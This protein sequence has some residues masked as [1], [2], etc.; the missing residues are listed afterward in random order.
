M[1]A[2]FCW[3]IWNYR[4]K[5]LFQNKK[6]FFR[7]IWNATLTAWGIR[8]YLKDVHDPNLLQLKPMYLNFVL[9]V[10]AVTQNNSST[11]GRYLIL[12][13]N[14]V[15]CWHATGAIGSDQEGVMWQCIKYAFAIIMCLY[16]DNM[17]IAVD[18]H[19]WFQFLKNEWQRLGSDSRWAEVFTN[20]CPSLVREFVFLPRISNV[21]GEEI[22]KLGTA[23]N[24]LYVWCPGHDDKLCKIQVPLYY[25]SDQ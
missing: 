22:I 19:A 18:N 2:I 5:I 16:L 17:D 12:L 25:F 15:L 9:V 14:L 3:T 7:A 11:L 20:T 6:H 10:T 4:N 24:G 1:V 21:L 23:T 13:S 8:P